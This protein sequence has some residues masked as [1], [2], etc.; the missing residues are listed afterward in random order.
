MCT[1]GAVARLPS[2]TTS[3]K[4]AGISLRTQ[5]L[6]LCLCYTASWLHYW[7]MQQPMRIVYLCS[8][9][10]LKCD[11]AAARLTSWPVS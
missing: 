6:P 8:T 5:I 1:N 9:I 4:L 11:D 7:L 3:R 2:S 10:L